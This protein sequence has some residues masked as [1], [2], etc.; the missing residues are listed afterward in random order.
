MSK[1]SIERNVLFFV[2]HNLLNKIKF[3]NMGRKGLSKRPSFFNNK[4]GL[5]L[6]VFFS[7]TGFSIQN[8]IYNCAFALKRFSKA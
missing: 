4:T 8:L 6:L 3:S 2:T 1:M 7:L 5:L